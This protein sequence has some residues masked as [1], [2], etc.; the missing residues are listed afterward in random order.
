MGNNFA[1]G[2]LLKPLFFDGQGTEDLVERRVGVEQDRIEEVDGIHHAIANRG[3]VL[4]IC[5]DLFRGLASA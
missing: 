1:A 2:N 3:E 5:E 4:R